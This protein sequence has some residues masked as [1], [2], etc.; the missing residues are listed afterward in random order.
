MCSGGASRAPI[1]CPPACD[2]STGGGSIQRTHRSIA[3]RKSGG[4]ARLVICPG[5]AVLLRFGSGNRGSVRKLPT[6]PSPVIGFVH[7]DPPAMGEMHETACMRSFRC[8]TQSQSRIT[9]AEPR[10]GRSDR[11]PHQRRAFPGRLAWRMLGV[12]GVGRY[13]QSQSDHFCSSPPLWKERRSMASARGW[14]AKKSERYRLARKT[15]VSSSSPTVCWTPD[16][17]AR[18]E[19]WR[20]A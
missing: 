20:N 16:L 14:L 3:G 12:Q 5:H 1:R 11:C 4:P 9:S 15:N 2:L 6:G 13:R 19:W 18:A 7:L 8:N 17:F 10:V